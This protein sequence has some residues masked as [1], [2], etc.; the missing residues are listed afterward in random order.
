MAPR[1]KAPTISDPFFSATPTHKNT[2]NNWLELIPQ[3]E[4]LV[5]LNR[6]FRKA[7]TSG[8]GWKPISLDGR[9]LG[10]VADAI[11]CAFSIL[12]T[13]KGIF[14]DYTSWCNSHADSFRI[15]LRAANPEVA[16]FQL[17]RLLEMSTQQLIEHGRD[18]G[19][20]LLL[21][22]AM[23]YV[24]VLKSNHY[25]QALGGYLTPAGIYVWAKMNLE[26]F[27]I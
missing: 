3:E 6:G 22:T 27:D 2:I 10:C 24:A 15:D 21:N 5:K 16:G 19:F 14:D 18:P 4:M 9:N 23:T 11:D 12:A 8:Q 7:T 26:E 20:D 13:H 25:G 17:N 1:V